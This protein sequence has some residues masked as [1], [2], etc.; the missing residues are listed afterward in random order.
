MTPRTTQDRYTELSSRIDRLDSKID[1]TINGF[2]REYAEGHAS[3]GN[4]VQMGFD[5]LKDQIVGLQTVG[6]F[7]DTRV[8]ITALETEIKKIPDE[9]VKK[10]EMSIPLSMLNDHEKTLK[11]LKRMF[12]VMIAP[13]LAVGVKALYDFIMLVGHHVS[14]GAIFP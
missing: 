9:F 12:W 6:P 5:S 2:R 8:R 1:E 3:L 7:A 10:I 11:S 13:A 4:R 14:G